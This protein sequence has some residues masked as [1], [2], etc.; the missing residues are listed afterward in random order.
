LNTTY[1]D[2]TT[3]EASLGVLPS[4]LHSL[5]LGSEYASISPRDDLL[6]RFTVLKSLD[7]DKHCYS[8][9]I[10]TTLAQLPLLVEIRLGGGTISPIGF[11]N[12]VSGPTRLSNLKRIALDFGIGSEGRSVSYETSFLYGGNVSMEDWKLSEDMEAGTGKRGDY[13]VELTRFVSL[14]ES[15]GI[16]VLG[17]IHEALA[18]VKDYWVE[19]SNRAILALQ[20]RSEHR[21]LRSE[22]F[23]RLRDVRQSAITYGVPLPQLDIDSLDPRRLEL[24]KI[25]LPERDWFMYSVRNRGDSEEGS[26]IEED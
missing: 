16:E 1:G 14:A 22:E 15:N 11:I 21:D 24:D 10:H 17:T 12:L 23:D 13:V 26:E 8:I 25:E 3:Y 5:K 4:T 18:L 19:A 2:V 7:L 6:R 9:E 20:A